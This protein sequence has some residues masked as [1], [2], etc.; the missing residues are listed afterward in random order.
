[1]I[2]IVDISHSVVGKIMK[3]EEQCLTHSVIKMP[4]GQMNDPAK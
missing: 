3:Y 4:A 1:M 2:I